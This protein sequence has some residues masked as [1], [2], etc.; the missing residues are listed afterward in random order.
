MWSLLGAPAQRPA[1][2]I[3]VPR[4]HASAAVACEHGGEE[5]GA[6]RLAGA[7]LGVDD[8][9]R[10]RAGPV[11]GDRRDIRA[12]GTLGLAGAQSQTG[13]GQ[14]PAPPLGSGLLGLLLG[15]ERLTPL[16][17]R[18]VR[19][20]EVRQLLGLLGGRADPS[21]AVSAGL[22]LGRLRLG[23]HGV[24]HG[25]RGGRLDGRNGQLVGGCRGRARLR[26][27][28]HLGLGRRPRPGGG[29]DVLGNGAVTVDDDRPLTLGVA[30]ECAQRSAELRSSLGDERDDL[31]PRLVDVLRGDSLHAAADRDLC[32]AV[33]VQRG[34][35]ARP[36][37]R[38]CGGAHGVLL[39]IRA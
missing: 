25:L 1:R 16:P 9:D 11:L 27:C 30:G 39:P 35:D 38:F 36:G 7:A 19:G 14:E 24:A 4:E 15:E 6:R 23:G 12:L 28:D 22:R 13:T 37:G 5:D 3:V 33:L 31:G 2:L 32:G 20:A 29:A 18:G 34:L 8:R 10:A 26:P 21:A 17:A